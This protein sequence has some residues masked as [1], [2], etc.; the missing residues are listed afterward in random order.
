MDAQFQRV[1]K[2]LEVSFPNVNIFDQISYEKSFVTIIT[3]KSSKIFLKIIGFNL[4]EVEIKLF[5]ACD[6][7]VTLAKQVHPKNLEYTLRLKPGWSRKEVG[8]GF[9][10][11]IL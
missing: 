3:K 8:L 9:K 5:R 11:T 7:H 4:E 6:S 2:D 10:R 1:K